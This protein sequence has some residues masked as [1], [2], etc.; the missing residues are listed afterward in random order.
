MRIALRFVEKLAASCIAFACVPLRENA[1]KSASV[2]HKVIVYQVLKLQLG[3]T[4]NALH[5]DDCNS[6]IIFRL[7]PKK[8]LNFEYDEN[9]SLV[10]D[11][12][13]REYRFFEKFVLASMK[14]E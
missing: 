7:K 6:A 8:A 4:L 14:L 13:I 11:A 2:S 1:N 9:S 5:L 12:I 3:D 10:M